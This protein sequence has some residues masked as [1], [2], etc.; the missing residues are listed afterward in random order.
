M[1][2]EDLFV[3]VGLIGLFLMMLLTTFNA[4]GRYL[5]N[6]PIPGSYEITE[7]YLMPMIVFLVAS[8]L[9]RKEGNISVRIVYRTLSKT[10]QT[11][12][13]LLS[14]IITLV[15]YGIISVTA[16]LYAWDGYQ[17]GWVTVGVVEFPVYLSW[18]ILSVGFGTFCLRLMFQIS[19]S[20]G[21]PGR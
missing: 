11:Y 2:V 7:L 6:A 14:R 9:Q 20:E 18:A 5:F 4:V 21:I 8:S 12:I 15:L 10:L 16:G 1:K 13:D 3:Y 17:R 19:K